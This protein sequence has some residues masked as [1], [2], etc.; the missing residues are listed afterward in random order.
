M[1]NDIDARMKAQH[2]WN[3]VKEAVFDLLQNSEQGMKSS[4]IG[5][6]LDLQDSRRGC[7][8][9]YVVWTALGH[10]M[11]DGKVSYDKATRL[12]RQTKRH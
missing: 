6:L 7:Q 5:H 2:G 11:N 4:A 1:N 12:Y 8:N 9:G 3:L 10:L